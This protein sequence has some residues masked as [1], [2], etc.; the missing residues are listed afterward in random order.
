VVWTYRFNHNHA[1]QC[2][3]E[4]QEDL[5]SRL[6]GA[7][8]GGHQW[9]RDILLVRPCQLFPYLEGRT[10]WI[11]GD[12]M[13]KAPPPLPSTSMGGIRAHGISSRNF[14][15]GVLSGL[16]LGKACESSCDEDVS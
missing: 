15:S 10:L 12:S 11:I 5:Q 2:P 3:A 1:P 7:A 6:R 13:S 9:A 8:E 16:T 4:V 14:A